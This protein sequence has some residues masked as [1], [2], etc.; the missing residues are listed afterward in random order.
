MF[1]PRRGRRRAP[2]TR[3]G[4]CSRPHGYQLLGL[5]DFDFYET[6]IEQAQARP[7]ADQGPQRLLE[8]TADRFGSTRDGGEGRERAL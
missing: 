5:G 4:T 1:E 8:R 6:G 3:T 7:E 2:G